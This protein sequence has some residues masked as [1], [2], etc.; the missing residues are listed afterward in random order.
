MRPL[1]PPTLG[2]RGPFKAPVRV[3]GQEAGTVLGTGQVLMDRLSCGETY[4]GVRRRGGLDCPLGD[5]VS[6]L[7]QRKKETKTKKRFINSPSSVRN[8]RP[9]A[10]SG[11]GRAWPHSQEAGTNRTG[12]LWNGSW[13]L[14]GHWLSRASSRSWAPPWGRESRLCGQSFCC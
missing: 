5:R 6:G 9:P 1:G 8:I 2:G 3:G 13:Q 14:F 10:N 12:E 4:R 11:L 7:R